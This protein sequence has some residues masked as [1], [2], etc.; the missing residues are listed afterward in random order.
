M[1]LCCNP[2]VSRLWW[3]QIQSIDIGSHEDEDDLFT[4]VEESRIVFVTNKKFNGITLNPNFLATHPRRAFIRLGEF[5][6]EESERAYGYLHGGFGG[7]TVKEGIG[8]RFNEFL[9]RNNIFDG[10]LK[11]LSDQDKA[12]LDE[13]HQKFSNQ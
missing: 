13:R 8:G 3:V 11:D 12:V 10:K 9:V 1:F 7:I 6:M 5:A 2:T 4:I